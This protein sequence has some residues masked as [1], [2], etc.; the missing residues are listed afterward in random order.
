MRIVGLGHGLF[1]IAVTSLAILNFTFHD[2]APMW[3]F[4][5]AGSPWREAWVSGS[6]LL[7]L[8]AAVGLCFSRTA[9]PSA[10][11]IGV[12]QA[13][14]AVTGIAPILLKPLGMGSWYGL[15]EALTSLAGT[16]ILYATLRWPSRGSKMPIAGERAVRAAQVLFGLTCVFYGSSHFAYAVYT[17]SMVPTWLPGRLGFAYFTGLS[18]IAAG[19]GI[20]VGILPRLAATLVALMMSMF[21]LL[22]W[23]PSFFAHPK[24]S[25][26]TPL[27]N[28]WSELEV[29]LLLAAAAWIV[30]DSLRSRLWGFA[31][32]PAKRCS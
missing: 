31:R 8:S 1:A 12:Y 10:L 20:I 15:C 14:W 29:N 28:E 11:T 23:V 6:A 25:W 3:H 13:I 5:P 4:I 18:Y 2:F 27:Q 9:L 16:W 32:E 7:L 21:G 19:I 17:A 30:A 22:V 24:P 26:A